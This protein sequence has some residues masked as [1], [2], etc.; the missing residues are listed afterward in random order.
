MTFST[1]EEL[2][3][4]AKRLEGLTFEQVIHIDDD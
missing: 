1:R 3:A 2:V 4:H